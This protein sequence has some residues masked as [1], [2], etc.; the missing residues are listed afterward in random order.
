MVQA[1]FLRVLNLSVSGCYVIVAVMLMRLI[2]RRAPR[3]AVCALWALAAVRLICPFTMESALSLLPSAAV[4]N[5]A[6]ILAPAAEDEPVIRTGFSFVDDRAN[7]AIEGVRSP[8]EPAASGAQAETAAPAAPAPVVD[9]VQVLSRIWLAGVGV[10]L[11]S[12]AGSFLLLRRRLRTAVHL[13]DELWQSER[14]DAPFVLGLFRPRIYLPFAMDSPALDHIIAH[15]RAHIR[16]HDPLTKVLAGLILSVHWF[17]PL[18]W[19]AY[20]L[21]GRDMELACDEHVIRTLDENDRK[22]YA[23][24]LLAW[25]V[26]RPTLEACPVAFGEVGLKERILKVVRYKKPAL[27]AMVLAFVLVAGAGA[28]LLT[29][30]AAQADTGP[31]Q[32]PPMETVPP[33]AAPAEA[34]G[35]DP[36][37]AP[38]PLPILTVLPRD[39]TA[40]EAKAIVTAIF[41]DAP[42]YADTVALEDPRSQNGTAPDPSERELCDWTF[43]P[44]V[45]DSG[46]VIGASAALDGRL[47]AISAA[48]LV[49]SGMPGTHRLVIYKVDDDPVPAQTTAPTQ[50]QIDAMTG[51]VNGWLDE[52][53]L[54]S[55]AI[56]SVEVTDDTGALIITAQPSYDAI[57]QLPFDYPPDDQTLLFSFFNG[58]LSYCIYSSPLE[59][60][61]S[62]APQALM[63]L[64][65]ALAAAGLEDSLTEPGWRFCYTRVPNADGSGSYHLVPSYR[66]GP[67]YLDADSGVLIVSAVDGSVIANDLPE[68][69]AAAEPT[70]V[71]AAASTATAP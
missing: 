59:V 2:L 25:G 10:M 20:S 28:C 1:L 18:C 6:A 5:E 33:S 58:R 51:Q 61:A 16:R 37:A 24:A 67:S 35:L 45:G 43:R 22:R 48:N 26:D 32:S 52:M 62:G 42:V 9:A 27:W 4:V 65:D 11:L 53:G 49:P 50:E 57:V 23:R 66:C 29:S 31:V 68:G 13:R 60:T 12:G 15:E 40:E 19:A 46:M 70:P 36:D 41:G 47:Y 34:A 14:V 69:W 39:V 3:W 55:Y 30:P 8:V 63:S 7:A 54:E 17:N 56:V 71:P 44:Q 21:L 64:R 38:G